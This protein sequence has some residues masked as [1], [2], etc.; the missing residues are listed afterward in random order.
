MHDGAFVSYWL[1]SDKRTFVAEADG[2]V[3]GTHYI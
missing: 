3:L 2:T 1:G